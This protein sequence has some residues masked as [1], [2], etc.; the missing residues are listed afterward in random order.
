MHYDAAICYVGY[1]ESWDQL[2]TEGDIEARDFRVTCGRDG[3]VLA[4][5][6]VGRDKESLLTELGL[7]AEP[8]PE[9]VW[10]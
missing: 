8:V 3:H 10:P 9:C 7:V 2:A 6:T 1:A 5:A 4:V